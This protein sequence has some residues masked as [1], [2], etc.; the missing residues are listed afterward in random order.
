MSAKTSKNEYQETYFTRRRNNRIQ[1]AITN[2]EKLQKAWLHLPITRRTILIGVADD[3]SIK[4]V[5]S[6]EE[7]RI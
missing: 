4:G 7:E 2:Y 5:K 6:E 1:K 3:G